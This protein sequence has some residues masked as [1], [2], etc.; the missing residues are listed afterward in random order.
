MANT[1]KWKTPIDWPK[2]REDW[3]N[4]KYGAPKPCA[5]GDMC[6]VPACHGVHPGEEGDGLKFYDGS[7]LGQGSSN[8]KKPY[9][10]IV[11]K[12]RYYERCR[13]GISWSD[14]CSKNNIWEHWEQSRKVAEKIFENEFGDWDLQRQQA[15]VQQM[16]AQEYV[17]QAQAHAY[18]EAQAQAHAQAYAEAQAQAQ[19]YAQK[20][21]QAHAEA[22]AQEQKYKMLTS[23]IENKCRIIQMFSLLIEQFID[24]ACANNIRPNFQETV[25]ILIEIMTPEEIYNMC[26]IPW[27]MHYCANE[28]LEYLSRIPVENKD[29]LDMLLRNYVESVSGSNAVQEAT[30]SSQQREQ[31]EFEITC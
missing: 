18:A 4:K 6:A 26:L 20:V 1:V 24:L 12:T 17:R 8:E 15:Q 22:Y 25:R 11:G 7:F 2:T 29:E 19:A 9:I 3:R 14:W 10:R 21:Q 30:E 27:A 13:R 5:I 23:Q 31:D 16:Q 28:C